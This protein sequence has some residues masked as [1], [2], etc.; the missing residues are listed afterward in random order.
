MNDVNLRKS[1]SWLFHVWKELQNT[2]AHSCVSYAGLLSLSPSL[3]STCELSF[4]FI[5][6]FSSMSRGHRGSRIVVLFILCESRTR[7]GYQTIIARISDINDLCFC[8]TRDSQAAFLWLVYDM[9]A[10]GCMF[11]RQQT[12]GPSGTPVRLFI[13]SSASF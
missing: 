2:P 7:R 8:W 4:L 9:K 6:Y 1:G 12:S 13:V 11:A 5:V 3:S 10:S